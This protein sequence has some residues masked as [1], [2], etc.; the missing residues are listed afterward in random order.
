MSESRQ[1]KLGIIISY[2]QTAVGVLISLIYT[3]V[4]LNMLGKSEY[5]LY[6]IAATTIS[7]VNL[8]NMGFSSSYVR[9][10]SK[11]RVSGDDE[12]I[13]RTNG[14]FCIVFTVI[15]ILA[16]A[17]GVILTSCCEFIFGTGLSSAEYVKV[18]TIMVILTVST[19]YNLATSVFSSIII[20]HERFVFHK[21]VNLIKSICSPALIWILLML[22][23]RSVMMAFV[24]AVLTI[25]A[26]T[27]Y[28]IYC[29]KVLKIKVNL[30]NPSMSQLKEISAFSGFIALSVAVDQINWS[31]DKILLGRMWGAAYT[32]V[33]SVAST[34]HT[35]YMQLSTAVSNVFIPRVNCIVAE[36]RSRDELTDLFIKIGRIQ[37]IVLLPILL[38]FVFFGQAFLNLWTPAGYDEVYVIALL[39]LSSSTVPYIQNIGVSI[40][41]AQNKHKFRAVIYAVIAMVN[42]GLSI[43]LC[44]Y[45]GAVGC[46]VGT[47]ISLIIGNGFIM[48]I[49]YHKSIG[50]NIIKFWKSIAGFLPVALIVS[51]V[52]MLIMLFVPMDSWLQLILWGMA[53]CAVYAVVLWLIVMNREEKGMVL[54]FAKNKLK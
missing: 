47:A 32:A 21:A 51:A 13:A 26:D 22:G 5:G 2:M 17:A 10:Y 31:V 52:G 50:I 12:K 34:I 9:F 48:N 45:F 24:T 1:L 23:Y 43:I 36:K 3:P 8:L 41:T 15:G 44:R 30:S 4:M 20:A 29:F 37:T 38:G 49:Y 7:Y 42:L 27:F 14:L 6:N 25:A 16:L 54:S 19:A 40:Q 53:F 28:L 11:D 18:K 35:L 33:Y 46:A 39:L